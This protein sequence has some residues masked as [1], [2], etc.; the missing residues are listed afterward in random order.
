MITT[1]IFDLDD[2]LYDEIEYCKSGFAAAA[3]FLANRYESASANSTMVRADMKRIY[4]VLWQQFN[5]G[6]R[7]ETFNAALD[8]LELSYDD[9]LISELIEVYRRHKP[10]IT[11]PQDSRDSL[12]ELSTKY[13]LALLTDGF[14]PGQQLKVQALGIE[15]YFKS[16][17]YTEQLGREFWKPSP[18]GFEKI[19]KS[20]EARPENTVY[21]ADNEKKDFIAP[22]KLDFVTIQI[23]R[24]ARLHTSVCGQAGAAAQHIIRQISQLSGLLERL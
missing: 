16:I 10:K 24:P 7:T 12:C 19:L 8:E 9:E 13:T 18:V 1:V 2:T 14:L 22:N 17:I 15:K 6:N 4:E 11:L 3:E 20:L 21:I 23:L 5:T